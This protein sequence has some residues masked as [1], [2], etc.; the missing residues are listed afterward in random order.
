MIAE[1]SNEHSLMYN[2]CMA[3]T[4][5]DLIRAKNEKILD[6]ESMDYLLGIE[7]NITKIKEQLLDLMSNEHQIMN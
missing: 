6:T 2:L 1:E 3:M 7:K 4:F 5:T